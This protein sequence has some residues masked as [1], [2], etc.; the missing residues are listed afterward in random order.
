M[1]RAAVGFW[2]S[3][4]IAS[5]AG[6]GC[7][8]VAIR[9][10]PLHEKLGAFFGRGY[11]LALVP[12]CGIYQADL[13]RKIAELHY[14]AAKE[15]E[16]NGEREGALNDLVANVAAISRASNE[17]A[18]RAK[19]KRELGLLRSQ[20]L[21]EKTWRAGLSRS[22]LSLFSVAQ[23]LKD[24]LRARRWISK[25]I[26]SDLT[27]TEDECRRFYD[28]HSQNF[29]L[30]ARLRASHLFLAA[31][32][33][34]PPEIVEAKRTAI[35]ALSVRL[36]GGE[37]FAT[38][39]AQNSEDEAT[40]LRG[41]DLGYFSATRMPPD[42]VEAATKLRPKEVSKPIRTRLGFHILKLIDVQPARQQTLDDVR[43][44]IAIELE[45]Q[46]RAVAVPKLV[47]DLRPE[48]VY[49]RPL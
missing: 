13:D 17:R 30:P 9:A 2:V 6:F 40:K 10:V 20:F 41:G 28:S 29:F 34:T 18:S 22:G 1:K 19:V 26:A 5:V 15:D 8:Q 49:L 36:V 21:D 23:V 4:G 3:I 32:P 16:T 47:V 48:A 14:L 38:L 25:S 44:D 46:K 43:S 27:V 11:L 39:A 42:F 12:G 33:E 45:N 31:P 7:G 37:D 35:E 24:D